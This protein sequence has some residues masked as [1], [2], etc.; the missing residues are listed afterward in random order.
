M[1][2]M[3]VYRIRNDVDRYQYF[4]T[5][6]EEEQGILYG[7]DCTPKEDA[8][9][10]P[11][12]YVLYPRHEAGDFYQFHS[13]VLIVS[14]RA[15]MLLHEH[16]ARAGELLPLHYRGHSY[17]V[18]NVTECINV[19]DQEKTEW[20]YAEG[21]RLHIKK[22]HFHPGRFTETTLFKIPETSD[23]EILAVTGMSASGG[24]REAVERANLKGLIYEELWS[25]EV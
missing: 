7:M 4:L 10:P 15:R 11:S 8:W 14:P 2:Q 12:V 22:Y 1:F 3:T 17:T 6:K 13:N 18:L 24:F 19:L 5:E 20:V 9:S 23:S 16:L 25:T 21:H